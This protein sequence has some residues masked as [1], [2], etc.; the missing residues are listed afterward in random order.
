MTHFNLL[1]PITLTMLVLVPTVGAQDQE[2]QPL[3][4]QTGDPTEWPPELDAVIA[5]PENHTVL[6]ENDR[7]RVF[8]VTLAPGELENLHHHRWP[9]VLH[10]TE[11]G[12]FIDR[13]ADGEVIFDSREMSGPLTLPLTMWKDPEAPHSVE[14]LST[15]Q[16][17]RLLRVELKQ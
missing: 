1:L 14:N 11:A 3:L 12:H 10:I 15:T 6:L 5:A 16:R 17:L 8:E 4:Y 13:N 9:S 7:V 2:A